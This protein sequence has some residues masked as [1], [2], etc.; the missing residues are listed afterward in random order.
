[1]LS[2]VTRAVGS[3]APCKDM[4]DPIT[5]QVAIIYIKAHPLYA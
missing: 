4:T 5:I 2:W 3:K 1:M